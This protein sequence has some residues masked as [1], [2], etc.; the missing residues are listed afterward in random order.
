MPCYHPK[1]KTLGFPARNL[2][3]NTCR[4]HIYIGYVIVSGLGNH[5]YSLYSRM[6]NPS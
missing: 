4:P 6:K 5:Q 1:V 3:K 2:I